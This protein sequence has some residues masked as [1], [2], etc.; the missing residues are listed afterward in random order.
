MT[1]GSW[2]LFYLVFYYLVYWYTLNMLQCRCLHVYFSHMFSILFADKFYFLLLLIFIWQ[3]FLYVYKVDSRR[4]SRCFLIME[5]MYLSVHGCTDINLCPF[6]G[7][8]PGL[9]WQ[10]GHYGPCVQQD[11]GVVCCGTVAGHQKYLQH[12]HQTSM[13]YRHQ[14]YLNIR[15]MH[16]PKLSKISNNFLLNRSKEIPKEAWNSA[17]NSWA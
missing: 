2:M 14:K 6:F 4:L 12:G 16:S 7:C 1:I 15:V 8:F 10:G 13:E 3:M 17:Q 9:P 5:G 11:G